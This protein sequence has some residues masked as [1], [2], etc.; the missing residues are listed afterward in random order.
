M[1][2]SH[3][4]CKIYFFPTHTSYSAGQVGPVTHFLRDP[5]APELIN[6]STLGQALFDYQTFNEWDNLYKVNT[7]SIFFVSNAFL[8]LL[9]SGTQDLASEGFTASIIN[10]TS[11]SGITKLAQRHVC[12]K[13]V[14]SLFTFES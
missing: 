14:F 13:D 6:A 3:H 12:N 4:A 10:I 7:S 5:S 11:I 9:D 2:S 8:G 1:R